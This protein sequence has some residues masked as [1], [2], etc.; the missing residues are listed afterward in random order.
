MSLRTLA[1]TLN[2]I[3]RNYSPGETISGEVII[4][5]NGAAN[6]RGL[7]LKFNGAAV[8]HWTER[9]PRRN[10]EQNNGGNYRIE[11]EP[12]D[13][14]YHAE[15][16]YF[17]ASMYVLGGPAGNV[18]VGAGRLVVPFTTPLPMNI[19]SSFADINLGRIEYSIEASMSTAWGSEFKTKILFYVN[20]PPNLS[21]YPCEPIVDVVN[22]KYYC[23]L[24][25]CITNGSMDACIRSLGNCYSIGEWIHVFLDI[26]SHSKSVQVTSVDMKLEQVQAEEYLFPVV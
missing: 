15:E 25:P 9:N 6:Y 8:V 22:K 18:H 10:R 16:E 7:Q 23:C 17:Q 11:D 14:H 13:V 12:S 3:S 19:P 24:L 5:S 1:I 20:A 21:Q 4:D 2:N 26:D